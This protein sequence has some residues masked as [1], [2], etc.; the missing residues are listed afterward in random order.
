MK[1]SRRLHEV[2]SPK[3]AL[4]VFCG[5][6]SACIRYAANKPGQGLIVRVAGR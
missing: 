5:S 2:Y 4:I 1:P 3:F 6:Q